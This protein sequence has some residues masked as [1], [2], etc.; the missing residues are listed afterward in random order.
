MSLRGLGSSLVS[1][2]KKSPP[3]RE[4][5][6]MTIVSPRFSPKFKNNN[7][8]VTRDGDE[9]SLRS[10]TS[11]LFHTFSPSPINNNTISSDDN[12]EDE[13]F[14]REETITPPLRT[15]NPIIFNSPFIKNGE[16]KTVKSVD[17][18]LLSLS[19]PPYFGTEDNNYNNRTIFETFVNT[20]K[21]LETVSE[22]D[23]I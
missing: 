3:I 5:S 22:I 23:E 8:T 10:S 6:N 13:S 1:R 2:E 14:S 7:L 18:G 11:D 12:S 16:I 19:P 4:V 20:R 21:E 9:P 15:S 17:I